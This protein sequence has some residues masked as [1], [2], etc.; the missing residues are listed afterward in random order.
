MQNAKLKKKISY[1]YLY[2]EPI[3]YSMTAFSD[4]SDL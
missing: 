3:L 2:A 1:C 4:G